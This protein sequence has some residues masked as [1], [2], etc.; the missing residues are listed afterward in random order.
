MEQTKSGLRKVNR[1]QA[2]ELVKES[3]SNPEAKGIILLGKVGTGKTETIRT[4]RMTT[5][6]NLYDVYTETDR[7]KPNGTE[8]V[9]QV[10]N[11]MI[12]YE[13]RNVTIDEIGVEDNAKKFGNT[14]DPI[15]WCVMNIYEA[16]QK[17][18]H[19]ELDDAKQI[20]LYMTSNLNINSL[21]T[22][23]GDRVID[24]LHQMCDIYVL[25]DTNLRR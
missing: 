18:L 10:I 2:I 7:N 25:D 24:R 4:S 16:N 3:K 5:A 20:R 22:R 14:L 6:R 21:E 9:R 23:Y 11:N 8:G 15:E 17:T 19:T 1:E 12:D 13:R